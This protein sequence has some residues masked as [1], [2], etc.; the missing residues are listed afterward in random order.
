MVPL[1]AAA[2]AS[3]RLR[4]NDWITV[5]AVAEAPD[6]DAEAA[7]LRCGFVL[8]GGDVRPIRPQPATRT[9]TA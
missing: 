2:D 4:R 6:L 5:H 7:R 3:L 1:E 9:R 8:D